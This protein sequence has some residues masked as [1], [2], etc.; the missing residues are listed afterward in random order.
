MTD[1]P[2]ESREHAKL[3]LDLAARAKDEQDKAWFENLADMWAKLALHL[4]SSKATGRP[5]SRA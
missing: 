2:K 3:Y 5:R 1:N 4:E